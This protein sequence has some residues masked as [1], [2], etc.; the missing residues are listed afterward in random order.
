MNIRKKIQVATKVYAWVETNDDFKGMFVKV[1]KED[2]LRAVDQNWLNLDGDRFRITK[3]H[4]EGGRILF[5]H[6]T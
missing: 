1:D 3:D 4:P 6:N 5:I 2:L